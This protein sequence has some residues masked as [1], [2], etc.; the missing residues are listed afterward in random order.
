MPLV[1]AEVFL[2]GQLGEPEGDFV[3]PEVLQVVERID[4]DRA[5]DPLD[6]GLGRQVGVGQGEL[7]IAVNFA[8]SRSPGSS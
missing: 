6:F 4:P 8:V 7:G 5:D 2:E 3:E 1:V